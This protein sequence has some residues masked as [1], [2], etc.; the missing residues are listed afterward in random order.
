MITQCISKCTFC[1]SGNIGQQEVRLQVYPSAELFAFGVG[2]KQID[3]FFENFSG[4]SY[5][6]RRDVIF[7]LRI[8]RKGV[9][10]VATQSFTMSVIISAAL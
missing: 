9:H 3:K 10:S 5:P 1:F 7:I 6:G 4:S 8:H 2:E